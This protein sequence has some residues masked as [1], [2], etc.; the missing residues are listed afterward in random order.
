MANGN[1]TNMTITRSWEA[2]LNPNLEQNDFCVM[3]Y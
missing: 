2:K 1:A 3:K